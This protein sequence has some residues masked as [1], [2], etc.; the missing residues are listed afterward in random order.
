[1]KVKTTGAEF[2]RFY[3]D[4]Q[5]WPPKSDT[6]HEDEVF[7]VNGEE[8][9]ADFD[10]AQVDD[11][12][13]VEIEGGVVMESPFYKEGREPSLKDY[14]RRWKKEQTIASFVV[15]CDVSQVE[16]VKKVVKDYLA[17][18]SKSKTK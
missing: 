2:K 3:N 5:Y 10:M 14:F 12:D 6:Y 4:E 1:M 16:A 17:S 7:L 15:E 18:V 13:S 9:H 8:V 11:A